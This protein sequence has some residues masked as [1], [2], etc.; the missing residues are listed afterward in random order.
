MQAWVVQKVS[1]SL[2]KW[3]RKEW[4]FPATQACIS[5]RCC[6]CSPP[7]SRWGRDSTHRAAARLS[8]R[9][10]STLTRRHSASAHAELTHRVGS[11]NLARPATAALRS[12]AL[13]HSDRRVLA[14]LRSGA[15]LHSQVLIRWSIC[16]RRASIRR[17]GLGFD[18]VD[19]DS[20]VRTS[21][22]RCGPRFRGANL[23]LATA[24]GAAHPQD[25]RGRPRGAACPHNRR[26]PGST[27][28]G[29]SG[30]EDEERD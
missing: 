21:I 5:H 10:S 29:T 16:R 1:S 12:G 28:A 9:C 3:K 26:R 30:E 13:P 20:G 4:M 18:C 11:G 2:H 19:L 22:Q 14:A 7:C 6:F 17:C 25:Q 15:R 24:R 23:D 27:G 8:H